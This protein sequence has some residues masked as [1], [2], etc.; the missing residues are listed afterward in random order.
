MR[1]V[2]NVTSWSLYP[3]EWPGTN[4][5]GGGG[6]QGRSG[7]VRK[8]SPP[9]R[10]DPRTVQTVASSYTDC[11]IPAQHIPRLGDHKWRFNIPDNNKMY[12]GLNVESVRCFWWILTKFRGFNKFLSNSAIW[13][14]K[15]TRPLLGRANI[16][17]LT[18]ITNL[19][20]VFSNSYGRI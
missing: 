17:G 7:R 10:F 9:P 16:R 18:K 1:V 13:N 5:T 15:K 3:R 6:P 4:F 14:F 19:T 20:G 12:L 11:V 2:V 8:G